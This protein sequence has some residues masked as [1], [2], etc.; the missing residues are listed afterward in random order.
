MQKRQFLMKMAKN[1]PL[2]AYRANKTCGG[3][4]HEGVGYL[5]GS[6]GEGNGFVIWID[7]DE[8]FQV[9][10]NLLGTQDSQKE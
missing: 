1:Q 10:E 4:K 8:V 6:D 9:L 3:H 2:T 7:E 5:C